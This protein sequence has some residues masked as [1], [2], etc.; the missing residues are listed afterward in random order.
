MRTAGDSRIR[1]AVFAGAALL[2]MVTVAACGS[3]DGSISLPTLPSTTTTTPDSTT[4]T[5][6]KTTTTTEA[7]TTTTSGSPNTSAAVSSTTSTTSGGSTT[8]T[9]QPTTTTAAPTTTTTQPATTTTTR[10]T[11][12]TTEKSTTTTTAATTTT[13]TT[14][15]GDGAS[16][17][18]GTSPWLWIGAIALLVIAGIVALLAVLKSRKATQARWLWGAR[19]L[20]TRSGAVARSLDE[21]AALLAGPVAVNR[22]VWLDDVEALNG[23]ATSAGVLAPDAPKVPGDPEGTNSMTAAL[24]ALGTNLTVLK[25]AATEAERIRFELVGPT[26]EQLDFASRSVRQAAATVISDAHAVSAA[27]DRIA[28]PAPVPPAAPGAPTA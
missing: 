13:P 6:A 22:Q 1:G 17:S 2:A 11:T 26:E 14:I 8:T 27:A 10:A 23:L 20:A 7:K 21:A 16:S 9:A 24:T 19:D 5:E 18:S 12:T 3:G 15:N 4:T 25:S 28:P